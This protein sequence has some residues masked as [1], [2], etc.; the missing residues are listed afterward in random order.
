MVVVAAGNDGRNNAL[1]NEGYGT[2]NAPGNDPYVIT[3][4]ATNPM[5]TATVNDD[6]M[7]TY[8][9]KGPS[10]IDQVVKPDFVAPGNLVTSLLAPG[11]KLQVE[12]PTFYTPT[13]WYEANGNAQASATYFPL[14]GTSM[15]TA[16]ASGA[17][18]DLLQADA[19]LTPDQ[20]KALLMYSANKH[21]IPQTNVVTDGGQTYTAHDD[22]FT[23]GTGYLDVQATIQNAQAYGRLIPKGAPAMSPVAVFVPG[24]NRVGLRRARPHFGAQRRYGA[25]Q[26]RRPI[27]RCGLRRCGAE[28]V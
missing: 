19:A 16:V 5:N 1:N 24:S 28:C 21:V 27:R 25:R 23:V 7:A 11:S 18:A 9:S 6:V 12:N 8:S 13:A 17:V 3:V 22:I 10:F 15:A 4:G 20:A 2:I 26:I 14:S